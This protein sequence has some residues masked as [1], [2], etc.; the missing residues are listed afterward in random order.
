[1]KRQSI[2]WDFRPG[3]ELLHDLGEPEAVARPTGQVRRALV[4]RGAVGGDDPLAQEQ[5]GDRARTEWGA[6]H[7]SFMGGEYLD[8]RQATEVEVARIQINS[9]TSDVTCVYL[10]REGRGFR[11]RV[12]D[13]YEGDTL[14]NAAVRHTRTLMTLRTLY[15]F[16][17]H[18]WPLRQVIL[19]NF[20]WGGYVA[21]EDEVRR[22]VASAY[23]AYY[24][25][26][27]R[28]IDGLVDRCL[29]TIR[30]HSS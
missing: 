14:G 1:M 19:S 18:V 13:E 11:Y 23:S 4:D 10:S 20:L 8:E 17:M 29:G 30:A 5:L 12:V 15:R 27:G 7:P 16:F 6:I 2:D 21:D 9:T 22:F 3:D 24:P 26:F 28:A 25:G